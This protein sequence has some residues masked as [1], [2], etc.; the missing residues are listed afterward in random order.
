MTSIEKATTGA[1]LAPLSNEQKRNLVMLARKAYAVRATSLSPQQT[2]EQWR[3]QQQLLACE[4]SSLTLATNED[5][6]YI[7]AHYLNLLGQ[8]SAAANIRAKA[9]CEPRTWALARFKKECEAA[10]DVLPQAEQYAAGFL[11][12]ARHVNLDT[13]DA[14]HIWHAIF[15]VRRRAAQLRRGNTHVAQRRA[16]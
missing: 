6:N 5:Y 14:N 11:R 13:A 2:F 3:H 10:R 9:A 15:I 7:R 16:S 1:A 12:N 4:R 8:K